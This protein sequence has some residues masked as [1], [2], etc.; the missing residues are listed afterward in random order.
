[1]PIIRILL[2]V[3]GILLLLP[4]FPFLVIVGALTDRDYLG[5]L[6]SALVRFLEQ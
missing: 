3:L 2:F 4:L 6:T 5:Y 1:M